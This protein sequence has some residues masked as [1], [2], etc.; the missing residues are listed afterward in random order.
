[1]EKVSKSQGCEV[2][3]VS[4]NK[5]YLCHFSGMSFKINC[6]PVLDGFYCCS[7][8]C[9]L[10][11]ATVALGWIQAVSRMAYLGDTRSDL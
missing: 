11:N 8:S 3:T 7:C 2:Y 1:M 6:L 10:K 9:S 5:Y 4:L